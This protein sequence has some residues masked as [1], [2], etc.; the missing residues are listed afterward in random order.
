MNLRR[1]GDSDNND[2]T[3]EFHHP[4]FLCVGP[5]PPWVEPDQFWCACVCVVSNVVGLTSLGA[6]LVRMTWLQALDTTQVRA[7]EFAPECVLFVRMNILSG[8][9]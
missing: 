2:S 3:K 7:P 6:I 8:S 9:F 4:W 5:T 1:R